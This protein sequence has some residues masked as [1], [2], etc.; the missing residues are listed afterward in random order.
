MQLEKR[1]PQMSAQIAQGQ[2]MAI[3]E[4]LILLYTQNESTSI[5]VEKAEQLLTS[6]HYVITMG[7]KGSKTANNRPLL[8]IYEEGYL[9]LEALVTETKTLFLQAAK[10]RLDVPSEVY[11]DT[12]DKAI[13]LFFKKYDVK[14]NA[15]ET[16]CTIDY[17]LTFDKMDLQ[18]ILY[19]KNYLELLRIETQFCKLFSDA[20]VTNTLLLFCKKHRLDP[21]NTPVN[22]FEIVFNNAL[23]SV[24]LDNDDVFV[25]IYQEDYTFIEA[26][27]KQLGDDEIKEIILD[28][29]L[30]LVDI[31]EI[32]Q[33]ELIAYVHQYTAL[34]IPRVQNAIKYETFA[35]ILMYDAQSEEDELIF[36]VKHKMTDEQ[37]TEFIDQ[38]LAFEST[39]DKMILIQ[40]KMRS[41]EDFVDM[42][43][44]DCLFDVE[45]QTA[46]DLLNDLE[47]SFLGRIIFQEEM[48]E[49]YFHLSLPMI[50]K[51]ASE[52]DISWQEEFMKYLK[53]LSPQ[54]LE[55]VESNMNKLLIHDEEGHIYTV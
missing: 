29:T 25:E 47:L 5:R 9:Q 20:T 53:R 44:S 17:P 48:S 49:D 26:K 31:L 41:L 45:Y 54:R 4:K 19:I 15:H 28:A 23:L 39:E 22:L 8:E 1:Q 10:D 51:K 12:F 18:G 46:F 55:I 30:K 32:D 27:L 14:F 43:A 6:I 52:L 24:L 42:L 3:L 40:E 38:L 50:H 36:E 7:M 34:F 35:N 16:M 33:P 11:N 2:I 21:L 13:P 37:F